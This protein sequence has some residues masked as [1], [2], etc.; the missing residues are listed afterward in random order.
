MKGVVF[1][2][3]LEMVD[4]KFSPEMTERIIEACQLDS[5]G[6]YTAVGTYDHHELLRLV[7]AL[8]EATHTPAADLVRVFGRHLF[9]RF[10]SHYA[11]FF[12]GVPSAFAFLSQ[13]ENHIHVEVRKLYPDAELPA[14]ACHAHGPDR[15]E[16]VYRSARPFADL[17][18]G[19]LE[20]CVEHFREGIDIER[21]DLAGGQ[22]TAVRFLLTRSPT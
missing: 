3:F 17:A 7:G 21:E 16:M 8:S 6:V 10:V 1:T 19:L 5:G 13:V 14:F 2:E 9:R 12:E 11:H 22:S 20:G 4:S 18:A 15:L